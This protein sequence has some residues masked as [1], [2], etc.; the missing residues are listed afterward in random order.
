[1][2]KHE[3]SEQFRFVRVLMALYEPLSAV[4]VPNLV[5]IDVFNFFC[6]GMSWVTRSYT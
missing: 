3:F 2:E 4:I 1:V 6:I 5:L